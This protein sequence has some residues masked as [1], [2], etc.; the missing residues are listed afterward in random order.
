MFSYQV[1]LHKQGWVSPQTAAPYFLKS[2]YKSKDIILEDSQRHL[3]KNSP[4]L[5]KI[6]AALTKRQVPYN[7]IGT[8]YKVEAPYKKKR[9]LHIQKFKHHL[10][11]NRRAE[12]WR[13]QHLIQNWL[14]SVQLSLLM[15]GKFINNKVTY[16]PYRFLLIPKEKL[17][18]FRQYNFINR[19]IQVIYIVLHF[20]L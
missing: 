8:I 9:R 16:S 3:G 12:F 5:Y 11:K 4:R 2:I 15:R 10:R 19:E 1:L 13:E 17:S 7:I 20:H 6:G 18:N 14:H